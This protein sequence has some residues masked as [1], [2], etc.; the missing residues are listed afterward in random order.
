MI[1]LVAIT[2]CLFYPANVS[3]QAGSTVDLLITSA[4]SLFHRPFPAFQEPL[5]WQCLFIL[6]FSIFPVVRL[7]YCQTMS[8]GFLGRRRSS[9]RSGG[10]GWPRGPSRGA[11]ALPLLCTPSIGLCQ[12]ECRNA[13][14]AAQRGRLFRPPSLFRI[15]L[16]PIPGVAPPRQCSEKPQWYGHHCRRGEEQPEASDLRQ[17]GRDGG[18]HPA[19]DEQSGGEKRDHRSARLRHDLGGPGLERGPYNKLQTTY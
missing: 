1:A 9:L 13:G 6:R 2:P 19:A 4:L 11:V 14:D 3:R 10:D 17:R 8:R 7:G 12:S 16:R 5:N 15:P 18:S